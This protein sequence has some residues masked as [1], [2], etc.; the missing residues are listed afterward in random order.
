MMQRRT[1]L[2]AGAAFGGL[3]TTGLPVFAQTSAGNVTLWSG[4]P[5][6]GGLGDQVARPLI[7]Q[8]R[9]KY[10]QPFIYDAKPGAGGRIAAEFVKR[11]APDGNT[12]YGC[13][14][15]VMTLH[16]HVFRKLPY[17]TLAD[18]VPIAGLCSYTA[19]FTA[20]PGLPA[21]IRTVADYLKWARANPAQA[22]YGVPATGSSLHLAGAMLGKQ[23]GVDMQAV[24]YKGGAP[25]LTDLRGGQIPVSFNV[26][27]EVL[28]HIRAG[29]LRALAVCAPTRWKALPETPTLTELGYKDVAFVDWLAWYGPA[30]IPAAK[31][32]AINAAVNEALDSTAMQ[33]VFTKIGLEALRVTPEGL[34]TMVRE[35]HA[36]W[37]RVVKTTGFKPED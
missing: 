14:S 22:N 30:G 32:N 4:F 37:A 19:V 36:F 21:E 28:P 20:G 35:N 15:T 27:S 3:A 6:G 1:L 31:V 16:P 10:P 18:F 8:M 11:A 34:G 9:G 12:L 13:P 7:E 17:D 5:V 33:E 24:P 23:S 25:L 2:R 29:T 26:V